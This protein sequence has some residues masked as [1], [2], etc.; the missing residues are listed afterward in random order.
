MKSLGVLLPIIEK[1]RFSSI[2]I[3]TTVMNVAAMA[4]SLQA[5]FEI[6]KTTGLPVGCAPANGTYIWEQIRQIG[7]SVFSGADATA[8]GIA[9]LLWSDFLFYGP[10][11]G[12]ERV[13][14]AAAVADCIKALCAFSSSHS[15]PA[16]A[17]HP[18]RRLFPEFVE[19]LEQQN[20]QKE[21]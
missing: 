5:G 17:S 9:A 19:Q 3:D 10:M 21:K 6:K 20:V 14:A 2:L 11:A 18:L 1:A 8:H 12:T 13:F 16:A 15:L 7:K 4:F